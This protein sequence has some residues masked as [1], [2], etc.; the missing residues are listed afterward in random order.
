MDKEEKLI[1]PW[2]CV[3]VSRGEQLMNNALLSFPEVLSN[4]ESQRNPSNGL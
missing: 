1:N 4:L 3:E 2:R